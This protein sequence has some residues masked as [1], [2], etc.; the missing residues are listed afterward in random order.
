[1]AKYIKFMHGNKLPTHE[2]K[3]YFFRFKIRHTTIIISL[4]T[5]NK[6]VL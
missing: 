5:Q 4:Y 3:D 1:M 2:L 6:N